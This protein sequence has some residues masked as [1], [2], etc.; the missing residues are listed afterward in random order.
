MICRT[1]ILL[2]VLIEYL[3]FM[4]FVKKYKKDLKEMTT[5]LMLIV[6][7]FFWFHFSGS[8]PTT[9]PYEFVFILF[10]V[11]SKKVR[12]SLISTKYLLS[13]LIYTVIL[14]IS[15]Y[16]IWSIDYISVVFYFLF[17]FITVKG[18][19]GLWYQIKKEGYEGRVENQKTSTRVFWEVF[20]VILV[21]LSAIWLFK[22]YPSGTSPDTD[23]QWLQIHNIIPFTDIHAPLH[24]L[25]LK[26]LLTIWDSYAIV[27][28]SNILLMSFIAGLFSS[29]LYRKGIQENWLIVLNVIFA[30]S[31]L[32][33]VYMF[34]YKDIPYVF[35]LGVIT[36]ILMRINDIDFTIKIRMGILL[37]I[38]LTLCYYFR[39]NGMVCVV[40]VS[41]YFVYIFIKKKLI[42]QLTAFILTF[43]I[44]SVGLNLFIYKIMDC[45]HKENGFSMQVFGSGIAAVVAA[46]GNVTDEQLDT[47]DDILGIQWIKEHYSP[48]N[49]SQLIWAKETNDPENF[50]DI[51]GNE[52]YNN[53]FVIGLGK[54]KKEIIQLYFKL[55]I[56][57]PLIIIKDTIYNT[58]VIWRYKST[59]FNNIYLL[60]ILTL[61]ISIFWKNKKIGFHWIVF[62]PI[63]SNILSI[64]ISTITNEPRYLLPT[65][66]LF[67]PLLF[68]IIAVSH[69]MDEKIKLRK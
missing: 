46:D 7:L 1:A 66:T 16:R 59:I 23:Y 55:L 2:I 26:L 29:Y 19:L 50:F 20:V 51:P 44:L 22:N 49:T 30:F 8:Y 35:I 61:A 14:T 65:F 32:S 43:I 33:L 15:A 25:F 11:I 42:K 62:L 41:A 18:F 10:F 68:Y 3:K 13:S 56:K 17:F 53:F 5:I 9:P 27:V 60:V 40:L 45:E 48:W 54:N 38:L 36:Y 69:E 47:I 37:G 58:Y 4:Y 21:C 63:L 6:V 31:S 64:A 67:P 57:N 39:Y 12:A 52:V 24:T 34:P 28:I